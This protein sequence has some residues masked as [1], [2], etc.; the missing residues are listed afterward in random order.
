MNKPSKKINNNYKYKLFYNKFIVSLMKNGRKYAAVGIAKKLLNSIKMEGKN[1]YLVI[2]N[3]INNIK[4]LFSIKVIRRGKRV[5]EKPFLLIHENKKNS[6]AIN[7]LVSS[8][9]QGKYNH[10][11]KNLSD[12][13]IEAS[14]NTGSAKNKQKELHKKVLLNRSLFHI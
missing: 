7:W 4:P 13:L 11:Y 2:Y 12:V 6:I 5:I 8:A 3:A 14:E 10:F 9:K 1:P